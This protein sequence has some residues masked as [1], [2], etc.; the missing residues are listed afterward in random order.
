VGGAA[1]PAAPVTLAPPG[2]GNDGTVDVT[3][4][5]PAWLEFDWQ[6]TGLEDPV[7]TAA[8]GRFRGHDRVIYRGEPL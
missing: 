6:G 3:L 2:F 7:G 5:V 4:D 1:D 8:F